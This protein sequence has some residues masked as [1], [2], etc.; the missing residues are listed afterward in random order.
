[1]FQNSQPS[2]SAISKKL[3]APLV[4]ILLYASLNWLTTIFPLATAGDVNIRPGVVVPIFFGFAFGPAIGFLT[5]M[6]GNILGDL[7]SGV[8]AFPV[9]TLTG[10]A[11]VDF[12]MGTFLPWQIGNGLMGMIPGFARRFV[13]QYNVIKDYLVAVGIAIV[14]IVIGM[15]TAS[16]LT[17]ALG[18]LDASFVFTQ[19]FVPAVWSNIYNIVFLLPV[20]LYNFQ[21][22]DINAFKAFRSPF[23]RRLLFLLLSATALPIILLGLFLVQPDMA[24]GS[25]EQG[26]ILFKLLFTIILTMLFVVVNASMIAQRLSGVIVNLSDAAQLMEADSLS[27]DHIRALKA[28]P[29]NDE[30]SQ[31]C[32]IFGQMAQ[33]TRVRQENMKRQIRQLH[34][35]IDKSQTANEVASIVESDYFQQ[36]ESKVDQLRLSVKA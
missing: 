16:W 14:A 20:L 18:V 7:M 8:V 9:A 29:G 13:P 27:T 10:N 1:M 28:T 32:R 12:A 11:F 25:S 17:V 35:K 26:V 3:V 33:E 24:G 15:G 36:L 30:I 4:G 6:G 5:G 2:A 22:F 31:L 23:M 21:N 19:Y 34:I